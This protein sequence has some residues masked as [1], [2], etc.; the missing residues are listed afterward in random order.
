M[1]KTRVA[2][3]PNAP[4]IS[5]WLTPKSQQIQRTG[6]TVAGFSFCVKFAQ[7][8]VGCVHKAIAPTL[9]GS[10]FSHQRKGVVHGKEKFSVRYPFDGKM[11]DALYR[12]K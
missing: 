7:G 9:E 8:S 5:A 2:F 4:A 3:L 10:A 1:Q 12:H 6:T 11:I